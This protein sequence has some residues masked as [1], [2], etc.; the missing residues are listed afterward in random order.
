MATTPKTLGIGAMTDARWKV[1]FDE[2]GRCENLPGL[3]GL[4]QSLSLLK[5]V[6]KRHGMARKEASHETIASCSSPGGQR[7]GIGRAIVERFF[8]NRGATVDCLRPVGLR[9]KKLAGAGEFSSPAIIADAGAVKQMFAAITKLDI[10]VNNAGLARRKMRS[11]ATTIFWHGDRRDQSP[12]GRLLLAARAALYR[13]CRTKTGRIINIASVSRA[14]RCRRFPPPIARQKHGVVGLTPGAG[15]GRRARAG[16]QV[17]GRVF[18]AFVRTDMAEQRY[19]EN[20]HHRSGKAAAAAPTG[21]ITEAVREVAGAVLW[22]ASRRCRQTSPGQA[23]GDG[24]GGR[25]G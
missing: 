1:I 9:A 15:E 19:R 24:L 12:M 16:L 7:A 21:R 2:N 11:T 14:L 8:A 17:N 13:C 4:H 23:L 18:P 20:R 3:D 6:N 5:F 25:M 22:F 10:L